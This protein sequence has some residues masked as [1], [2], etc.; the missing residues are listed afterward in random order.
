[1]CRDIGYRHIHFK[2]EKLAEAAWSA[3]VATVH[4]VTE[5]L[6]ANARKLTLPKAK[7]G[8][9]SKQKLFN[10]VIQLLQ[11]KQLGW[12]PSVIYGVKIYHL[13]DMNT[14]ILLV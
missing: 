2:V 13:V 4:S 14:L 11:A 8:T 12:S 6:M 9:N 5:V 10:A 1:M 7:S 3:E